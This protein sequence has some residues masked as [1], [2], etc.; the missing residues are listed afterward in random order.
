M[1]HWVDTQVDK[2]KQFHLQ[3]VGVIIEDDFTPVNT[4]TFRKLSFSLSVKLRG[5]YG[6]IQPP[7]N[8]VGRKVGC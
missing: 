3:F 2:A 6:L 5:N 8:I 4:R 1:R 7:H